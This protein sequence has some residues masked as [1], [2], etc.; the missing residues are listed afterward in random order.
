[1]KMEMH[2]PPTHIH[3]QYI[4]T[5][6]HNSSA[7]P[8]E[9]PFHTTKGLLGCLNALILDHG[10]APLSVNAKT[11]H[12][13]KKNMVYYTCTQTVWWTPNICWEWEAGRNIN[14]LH[15]KYIV[16]WILIKVKKEK[17]V[18]RSIQQ[19]TNGVD[20]LLCSI[21]SETVKNWVFLKLK[22]QSLLSKTGCGFK[23]L[24]TSFLTLWF[25][26]GML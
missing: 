16:L 7:I 9:C 26:S 11:N 6:H 19:G 24:C 2:T 18:K 5:F 14:M 20:Q 25:E 1:M 10:W 15:M 17:N 22:G 23:A 13:N 3:I 4:Q 12:L 21:Q 8:N